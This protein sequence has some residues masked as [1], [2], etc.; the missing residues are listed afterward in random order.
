M[1]WLKTFVWLYLTFLLPHFLCCLSSTPHFP[2]TTCAFFLKRKCKQIHNVVQFIKLYTV[3][4]HHGED[5]WKCCPKR[6]ALAPAVAFCTQITCL[7]KVQIKWLNLKCGFNKCG[8]SFF[9]SLKR[10]RRNAWRQSSWDKRRNIKGNWKLWQT[11]MKQ[12]LKSWNS[13]RFVQFV[14][15]DFLPFLSSLVHL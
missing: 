3:C 13:F 6:S 9:V 2:P 7:L 5:T 15:F 12:L 4:I 11:R 10:V 1:T 14:D 8:S